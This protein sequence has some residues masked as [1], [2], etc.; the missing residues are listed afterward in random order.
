MKQWARMVFVIGLVAL[1]SAPVFA[2]VIDLDDA[3]AFAL[4]AIPDGSDVPNVNLFSSAQ[5][6]GNVGIGENGEYRVKAGAQVT[7]D[8]LL[9]SGVDISHISGS[10][11]PGNLIL[12]SDLSAAIADALAASADAANT[13]LFPT[14]QT[15]GTINTSTTWLGIGGTNVIAV[16]T[17]DLGAFDT[18]TLSGNALDIFLINVATDF[19]M[20]GSSSI[21]GAGGV[22]PSQILFNF[23]TN[24]SFLSMTAVSS[25]IGTFLAPHRDARFDGDLVTGA[26]IANDIR[27]G[28]SGR[29]VHHPFGSDEPPPP[30]PPPLAPIPEPASC[31]LFGL[32]LLGAH[33]A[34]RRSAR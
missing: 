17:I 22:D 20:T 24:G 31:L 18:L 34:T 16:D 15:F 5:I 21:V 9:E 4:L 10:A 23:P 30:P 11:N 14:T 13:T 28:S 32:G 29:L 33:R 19:R 2:A 27:I 26:V 7:G 3:A 12:N 25:G 6:V 1:C 8:A